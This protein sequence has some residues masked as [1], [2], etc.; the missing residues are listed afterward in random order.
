LRSLP[1]AWTFGSFASISSLTSACFDRIFGF[2]RPKTFAEPAERGLDYGLILAGGWTIPT[3]ITELLSAWRE[4]NDETALA[5]LMPLVYSELRRL[6]ARRLRLERTGHTLQPTA[7][8]H[9]AYVRLVQA[10]VSVND[11]VHFFALAARIMRRVLVDHARA[12]NS[13]KRGGGR[14]QITLT[15]GSI[16]TDPKGIDLLALDEALS[17]LGELDPRMAKVIELHYFGGL[18]YAETSIALEISEAT[19]D[20]QLRL[21]KAWLTEQLGDSA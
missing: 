7:L 13:D 20:R 18:T 19:V 15:D 10:E 5:R 14:T 21:A 2:S 1:V 6:A 8:V 11:R 9:E 16:A 4:T 12:R 17:R 3:D